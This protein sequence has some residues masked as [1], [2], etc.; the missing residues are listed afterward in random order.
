MT[1]T[2]T[3][4]DDAPRTNFFAAVRHRP[5]GEEGIVLPLPNPPSSSSSTVV[6]SAG[7]DVM[8]RGPASS[9]DASSSS[10]Q[11]TASSAV[12]PDLTPKISSS[13][14]YYA[15][16]D[17]TS[18]ENDPSSTSP[19]AIVGP[20]PPDT[21]NDGD[22]L[23]SSRSSS[24]ACSNR[25]NLETSYFVDSADNETPPDIAP[26]IQSPERTDAKSWDG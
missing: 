17:E 14:Y 13:G 6:A 18:T 15:H 25:T 12:D 7:Y 22:F 3:E 1:T 19:E 5:P 24:K 23:T 26:E 20:N 2:T 11:S 8:G 4:F 10:K 21:N 16:I 9:D